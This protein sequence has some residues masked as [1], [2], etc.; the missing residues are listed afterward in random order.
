M[1]FKESVEALLDLADA[2]IQIRRFER[3]IMAIGAADR[4][5]LGAL[6]IVVEMDAPHI[7]QPMSNAAPSSIPFAEPV[8]SHLTPMFIRIAALSAVEK[9][10]TGPVN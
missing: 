4:W 5:T 7:G 1:L 8:F 2:A 9:A 6:P 10:L 3:H